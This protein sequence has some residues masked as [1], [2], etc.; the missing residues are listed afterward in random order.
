MNKNKKITIGVVA[1]IALLI[2]G[3]AVYNDNKNKAEIANNQQANQNQDILSAEGQEG[4]PLKDSAMPGTATKKLS[5]EEALKTYRYRFQ[6]SDCHALPGTIS[7]KKGQP[8]MLDNRDKAAHTI[9]AN[10]QTIRVAAL[11]Y[12]VLI[13]RLEA[14]GDIKFDTSNVTCDGGGSAIL[15]VEK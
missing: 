2:I 7:V 5:Y 10:G 15:N 14:V 6:F 11:D 4:A 1:V 13:P 8:V 12:A 9:R 3:Y